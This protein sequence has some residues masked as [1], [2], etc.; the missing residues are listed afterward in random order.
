M[1]CCIAHR[2]ATAPVTETPQGRAVH[3]STTT[4]LADNQSRD[5]RTA[6]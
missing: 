1:T 4:Q 6:P 2:V 3:D 5:E